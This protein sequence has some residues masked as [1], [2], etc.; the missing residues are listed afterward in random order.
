MWPCFLPLWTW[1]AVPCSGACL[2]HRL[3]AELKGAS[4]S[5]PNEAILVNTLAI[6]EA[7]DSSA[8]ENIIT[9]QDE[10]HR[11]E[12]CAEDPTH[13]AAKEVQHYARALYRAVLEPLLHP[14]Q[15]RVLPG[16]TSNPGGRK[17]GSLDPFRLGR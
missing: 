5:I 8:I 15:G 12:V 14:A 3:L 2:G 17:L 7:R 4:A 13:P 1:K 11:A 6:Q 16:P 9:T 10:F